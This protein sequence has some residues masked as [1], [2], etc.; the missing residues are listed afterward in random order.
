MHRQKGTP[1]IPQAIKDEIVKKHEN[2]RST[3]ELAEEY[4]K[5]F[6]TI[7]GC[8]TVKTEKTAS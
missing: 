7:K 5:T 1:N 3:R 2:G 4:G 8:Y 6:K